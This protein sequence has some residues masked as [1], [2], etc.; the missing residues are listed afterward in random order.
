MELIQRYNNI[1]DDFLVA[2]KPATVRSAELLLWNEVLVNTLNIPVAKSDAKAILTGSV[3][4]VCSPPTA[5]AYSGHQFGHFN[6]TLGDGR[7]H[8]LGAFTDSNG[9]LFDIQLKGSGRTP[10]SRGGDGLCA[11]GPAVREYVMSQA[12]AALNVPTTH[13]LAVISTGQSV[14]RNEVVPGAIVSRIASSHIRVGS[15]QYLAVHNDTNGLRNLMDDAIARHYPHIVSCG[16]TRVIEFLKAVC[17][18]QIKLVIHWLRV[19]FIHG[20][21]NTDNTLVS[22]ETIDYGPCAMME[23][24]DFNQVFSSIDK[25]GRYAFGNQPNMA[26][27]NCARLAESLMP[28]I[29]SDEESALQMLSAAIAEFSAEFNEAYQDMWA[30]KLGIL[31]WQDS[32]NELLSELLSE[33]NSKQLDYT[34]TFAALTNAME[35]KSDPLF[36]VP[37]ELD[38]W[39]VKWQLRVSEYERSDVLQRMKITN[40][41]VI[42]RNQLIEKVIAEFNE[43]GDSPLLTKWL[44]IL[45]SPYNYKRVPDQFVHT[46]NSDTS[47]QTF[48]GT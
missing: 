40:P 39:I 7:A 27:W 8:L 35:V 38:S 23:R 4:S 43:L 33:M 28:L 17:S 26:N 46:A 11:L 41:S 44:P 12:M 20:V 18:A 37:S 21:M 32:D 5:L 24:F 48:C 16:S 29:D 34:N 13:C 9:Q 47:Y 36:L 31:V 14:I 1:S 25:Q 19:G 30:S 15:F 3:Q 22:G 45:N 2:S 42:P 10:F 6:P